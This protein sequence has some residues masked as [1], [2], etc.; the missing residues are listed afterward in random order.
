MAA[1]ETQLLRD[2]LERAERD[3]RRWE[4]CAV[5]SER[6]AV[7]AR[8]GRAEAEARARKAEERVKEMAG[9]VIEALDEVGARI[10]STLDV[11]LPR[12]GCWEDD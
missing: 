5:E 12:R 10:A 2:A 3:A 7:E 6:V 1:D 4:R 9:D 8:R 11:Q